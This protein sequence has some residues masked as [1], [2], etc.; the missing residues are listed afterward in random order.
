MVWRHNYVTVYQSATNCWRTK[1]RNYYLRLDWIFCL[2]PA[3]IY[4]Y[5]IYTCNS[6]WSIGRWPALSNPLCPG[7]SFPVLSNFCS[8]SWCLSPFHGVMYSL[9]F[10]FSFEFGGSTWRP[11]LWPGWVCPIHF[12]SFFLH[13]DIICA[14]L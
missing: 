9:V 1:L 2:I 11:T 3:N 6:R 7:P 12:Q 14:L 10:L 5:I 4:I 13:W 8:L